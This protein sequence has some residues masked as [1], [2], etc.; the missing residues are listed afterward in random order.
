MVRWAQMATSVAMTMVMKS[1]RL[2]T[3]LAAAMSG[4]VTT[5]MTDPTRM[6]GVRR[7]RRPRYRSLQMPKSGSG[8]RPK[9]LSMAMMAPATAAVVTAA[10]P[11]AAFAIEISS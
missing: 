9:T 10:A 1:A 4:T 2:P 3:L 8:T 5:A 11:R 7:P 6:N